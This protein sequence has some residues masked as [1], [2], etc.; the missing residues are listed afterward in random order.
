MTETPVGVLMTMK[1]VCAFLRRSRDRV[2]RYRPRPD[3]P[4]PIGRSATGLGSLLFLRAGI[5][6]WCANRSRRMLKPPTDALE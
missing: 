1:D 4:K 6:D 3:F 2:D 5:L